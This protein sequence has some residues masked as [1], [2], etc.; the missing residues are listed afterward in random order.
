MS[1][2]IVVAPI[3]ISSWPAIS[4]AVVAAVGAMGYSVAESKAGQ[5][6]QTGNRTEIEVENSEIQGSGLAACAEI[7]VER[8]GIRAI[9]SRYERG[10]LKLCVEGEGH[11]KSELKQV[12]QELLDRVTQQ[13][14]YHR[15]VTELKERNMTIV[16]EEVTED[17]TVRIRVRNL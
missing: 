4:A 1:T 11:S 17:R 7:I 13:Y 9:F 8:D 10:A 5:R 14:V 15:V 12:G 2:I 16:D 3:I 6:V